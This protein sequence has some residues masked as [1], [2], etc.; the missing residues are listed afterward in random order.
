MLVR[1]ALS[2]LGRLAASISGNALM[3]RRFALLLLA[4]LAGAAS[5]LAADDRID[6]WQPR[7][8]RA[9]PLVAVVGQNAGTEL[10]DFFVPFGVLADSGAADVMAL[11]TEPGPMR[12]RPVLRLQPDATVAAFDERFPQGAD[13]VVVPAVDEAHQSDPALL[14]WLRAQAAKGATVVSICDGAFVAANAGL[15]DG[16]RATGH[17]ATRAQREREHPA[18]HW[19]HDARWVA[20]GKVV[21]S[22]GVSAAIPTSFALVEAIAGREVALATAAR[23]GV[24]AWDSRHDSE[25]FRIDAGIALTYAANRWLRPDERVELAIA[26]GVDDIALALTVDAWARTLRSPI[27]VVFETAAPLRTRHALTLLPGAAPTGTARRLPALDAAPPMQA[28]DIALA[29]IR[30]E[31]GDATARFVALQ[32]EYPAGY[33]R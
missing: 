14:A 11:A 26:D 21:S 25:Q 16:H 31:L 10:I 6:A 8:G 30:S 19:E 33:A 15:F 27:A 13:Y 12:M 2:S 24:A 23:L 1:C 22:A 32:L 28:L 9:R 18:T 20:D 7:F 5:A 17:W 4:G 3:F 29:G